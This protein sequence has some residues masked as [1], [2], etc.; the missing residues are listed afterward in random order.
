MK[1]LVKRIVSQN[2]N[3]F[4][5]EAVSLDQSAERKDSSGCFSV[6]AV[7]LDHRLKGK[8]PVTAEEGFYLQ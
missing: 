1:Y 6:E 8:I 4:S 2:K 5:V 7:G 3:C